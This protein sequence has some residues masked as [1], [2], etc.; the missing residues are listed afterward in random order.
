M[1]IVSTT[2]PSWIIINRRIVGA[3]CTRITRK[4]HIAP[5]YNDLWPVGLSDSLSDPATFA[6]ATVTFRP[7]IPIVRRARAA[8]RR[9]VR[10]VVISRGEGIADVCRS[11][12]G[13]SLPGICL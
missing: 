8:P 3:E 6:D 10:K 11:G 2:I 5:Q 9:F 13:R 4:S 1:Q 12:V 7:I